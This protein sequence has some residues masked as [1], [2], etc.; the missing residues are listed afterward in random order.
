MYGEFETG[1]ELELGRGLPQLI[2]VRVIKGVMIH[3]RLQR[4]PNHAGAAT[5]AAL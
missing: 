2:C 5:D 3:G 4:Q 1:R